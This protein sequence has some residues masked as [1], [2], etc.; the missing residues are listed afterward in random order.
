MST[1][2]ERIAELGLVIPVQLGAKV[3]PDDARGYVR[4]SAI[5]ALAAIAGSLGSLDRQRARAQR[6]GR[7]C[8]AS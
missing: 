6:G 2:D 1:L 3:S 4:I 8:P 7:G 5:N